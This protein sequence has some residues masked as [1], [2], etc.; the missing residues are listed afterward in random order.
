MDQQNQQ[1]FY[2]EVF[3]AFNGY[4]SDKLNINQAEL[5]KEFVLEKF[6]EKN[7]SA[8]L[9]EQF[10]QVLRNAEEALY[11]PQSFGKMQEDYLTAIDWIV[12]IEH[13]IS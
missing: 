10:E 3:D 6:S 1:A 9:V 2:N 11:S 5:S 12:K 8:A 7:V 4:V 13:E